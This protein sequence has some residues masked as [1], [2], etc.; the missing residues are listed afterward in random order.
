MLTISDLKIGTN[1]EIEKEPYTVIKSEHTHMG[2][3]GATVRVKIKNLFSDKILE[4]TYKQAD[5][6][7]EP[8]LSRTKAQFL[9]PQGDSYFFMDTESYE[10]FPLSADSL[11]QKA[12]LLKEGQDVDV[13]LFQNKP[14]SI[15]LPSKIELK[16]ASAPPGVRGDTA[17]GSV[18]KTI[19]LETGLELQAPL[20]IKQGDTIRINT[21]TLEYVERV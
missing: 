10:Q 6:L 7:D 5:R 8:D 4:K 16:V 20:F 19:T 21:D 18:T 9:Y 17:Q 11:G 2:R 1:I 13:L 14:V 3:G 15:Q 12:S